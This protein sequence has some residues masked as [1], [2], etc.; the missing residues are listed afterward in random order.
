MHLLLASLLLAAPAPRA[1][2]FELHALGVLGGDTDTNLSCYLLGAPGA[3]PTL[4]IDGGS[5]IPGL[6][7]WLELRG[8]LARDAS[9]TARA[10]AD[11]EALR[12]VQALLLTHAHLDHWG[13]FVDASTLEVALAAGGRSPLQLVGLPATVDAIREHLFKSPL[14]AD[15]TRIP[16]EKQPAIALHPLAPG[17]TMATAG[18]QVETVG[19]D[20]AVPSAAFLIQS[21]DAAYLHLGDTGITHA[22]WQRARPLLRAHRLRA[23]TLELSYGANAE[24]LAA[25]TGH[26]ARN[27]FL[28]QLNELAQAQVVTKKP[29]ELTDAE[30]LALAHALAPSFADCPVIVTHVKALSYDRV[31]AEVQALQQAGLNLILPEQGQSYRF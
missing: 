31:R 1:P 25:T 29:A 16:S 13:G 15:F 26:L 20:H 28:L 21:G 27:S 14:W 8:K 24:A 11:L 17:E 6:E 5:V 23:V 3:A 9:P 10:K 4:M 18:F 12:P 7:K 30:A 19:L 22:V 2:A